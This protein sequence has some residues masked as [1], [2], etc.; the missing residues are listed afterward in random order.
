MAQ[1]APSL[2]LILDGGPVTNPEV[3]TILDVTGDPPCLLRAGR[4]SVPAIEAVLGTRFRV[5]TAA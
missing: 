2:D 5:G 1:L 3:S 4:I